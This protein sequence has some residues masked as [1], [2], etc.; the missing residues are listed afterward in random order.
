MTTT[1]TARLLTRFVRRRNPDVKVEV[2]AALAP[3]RGRATGPHS[4]A[5]RA[6]IRFAFGKEPAFIREGASIGA[7]L[8]MERILGAPVFFLG[9]SLPEHGYHAP[10]ENYDWRQASG[11]MMAFAEYFRRIGEM[12]ARGAATAD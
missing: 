2:D 12:A 8:T 5:L 6:A 10:N 7:V 1:K 3:Y 4:D 11:G 9:L